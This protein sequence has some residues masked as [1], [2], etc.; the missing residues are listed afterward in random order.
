MDSMTKL[1]MKQCV[2]YIHS[3]CCG[4]HWELVYD[5][6]ENCYHL[7]C[8]VCGRSVGEG[9]KITGPNL[10]N[11]G[12]HVCHKGIVANCQEKHG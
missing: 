10:A 2:T 11:S 8:E 3:K 12:C 5:P 9:I 4:K 6:I 7:V 1:A